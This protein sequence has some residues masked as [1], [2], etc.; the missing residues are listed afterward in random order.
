MLTRRST[1]SFLVALIV[2]TAACSGDEDIPS[3]L[4]VVAFEVIADEDCETDAPGWGCLDKGN[5]VTLAIKN[6]NTTVAVVPTRSGGRFELV[7]PSGRYDVDVV[8]PRGTDV[9]PSTVD[10]DGGVRSSYG[11]I[12]PVDK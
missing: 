12:W 1:A 7:L 10:F 3:S 8:R 6:G 5:Q 4:G 9:D 2:A 11:V